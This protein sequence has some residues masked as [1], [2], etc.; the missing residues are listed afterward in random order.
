MGTILHRRVVDTKS[1]ADAGELTVETEWVKPDG[2][3]LL[4]EQTQF[5]FRGDRRLAND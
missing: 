3:P 2:K 1:G 5:V 4:R